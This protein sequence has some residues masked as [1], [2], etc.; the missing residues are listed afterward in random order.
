MGWFSKNLTLKVIDWEDDT[1]DTM[2]Y[3]YPM[4]GRKIFF[5][6]K[7]TVRESQSAVFLNK[8]EVAD[9][10]E[11]GMYTLRSSNLPIISNLLGLPYGFKSPFFADV[12][13]VNTKQFTNQKWGTTNP[14]TLRDKDFG[15]IRIRAYGT[16]SFK[17]SD[18]A[19]FLR[20]LFGTNSSF[21]T[22]DITGHLR[23]ML[24]SC[25]SDTIAESKISALDLASNLLEFNKQVVKS[26]ADHFA[27]LGL[28]VTNCIIENISFPEAVEKAIDTRSSL[29]ILDDSMD[30][31]VKYQSA[32][33]LRD[34]A[35]NPGVSGLGTQ[36]GA[37]VAIG[38]ILKESLST[39]SQKSKNEPANA[40]EEGTKACPKCGEMNKKSDKFCFNC[41]EKLPMKNDKFCAQC[42]A[43]VSD[44]DKF[45]GECGTKL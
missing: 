17:V 7:L 13:F 41:G 14:I 2:V 9:V 44:K 15:T 37:G 33:A 6:S 28:L 10:F 16:Y 26:V 3:K 40:S 30:T 18:P 4:D 36:L 27:T 23:S 20:E 31:Y 22:E 5:G 45:C 29:G 12:Y 21:T 19:T 38:S 32:E 8:G 1:S 25:I 24:I 43:K 34:A 39:P 11:P 35:K 42:G